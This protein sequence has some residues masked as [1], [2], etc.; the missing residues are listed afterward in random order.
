MSAPFQSQIRQPNCF[1]YI[2]AVFYQFAD[3]ESQTSTRT[4]S[5]LRQLRRLQLQEPK[6]LRQK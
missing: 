4:A 6:N 1:M 2:N 5:L 3:E